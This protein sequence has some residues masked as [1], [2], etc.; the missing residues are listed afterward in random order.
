MDLEKVIYIF[1]KNSCNVAKRT[2][3]RFYLYNENILEYAQVLVTS[4]RFMIFHI[5]GHSNM[6]VGKGRGHKLSRF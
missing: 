2:D 6:Y 1:T 4:G 5:E 3:A